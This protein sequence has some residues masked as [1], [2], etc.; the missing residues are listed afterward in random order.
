METPDELW[1][2]LLHLFGK[3]RFESDLDDEI[4]FHLEMKARQNR[5]AGAGT[6]EARYAA[7]RQFGNAALLREAAREAWGWR[8]L[9]SLC[10]D[11]RYG[12]RTLRNNAGFSTVAIITLAL[13]IGAN[14][15]V[16]SVLNA[17]LLRDLAVDDPGR[18]VSF[19]PE[20]SF[21]YPD[22]L[23]FRQ[24]NSSFDGLCAVYGAVASLSG[25]DV[26]D[27]VLGEVVSANYFAVAGVRPL[28]GRG[29][30]EEEDSH[31]SPVVVLSY[32]L[33]RRN[34]GAD[35]GVLG[36]TVRI[37]GSG[38]TVIGIA[39]EG[40]RG[41]QRGVAADFWAPLSMAEHVMRGRQKP[42]S[43]PREISA[44]F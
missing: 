40:F 4:A 9:D 29:F 36:K 12:F 23:D 43:L 8:W 3:R 34:F 16:F 31:P 13:G 17:V 10:Q 6:E 33:W 14:T 7:R 44:V 26:A 35:A 37:N 18:L 24:Q 11:L 5:E 21:S 28:L 2:R 38:Y 22:Y 32:A 42:G 27:S 39:P 19:T 15:T 20:T 41:V 1:R 30:V 25:G